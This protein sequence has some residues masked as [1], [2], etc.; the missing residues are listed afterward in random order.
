M[1]VINQFN[2][3]VSGLCVFDFVNLLFDF[4]FVLEVY[5]MVCVELFIGGIGVMINV[6]MVCLF[7]LCE[8][9][10]S[11]GVKV[12]YDFFVGCFFNEL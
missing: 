2:N 6:K 10:V 5:K 1:F 4:I 3:G 8:C 7:D 9:V 11:I 12:N